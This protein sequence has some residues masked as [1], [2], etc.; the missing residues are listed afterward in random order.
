MHLYR[1]SKPGLPP[2]HLPGNLGFPG[3]QKPLGP[4]LQLFNLGTPVQLPAWVSRGNSLDAG[5]PEQCTVNPNTPRVCPTT[6]ECEGTS[7]HSKAKWP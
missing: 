7:R 4:A 3:V 2:A 6:S 1:G 5:F